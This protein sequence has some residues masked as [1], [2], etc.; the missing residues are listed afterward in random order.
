MNRFDNDRLNSAR[1]QALIPIFIEELKADHQCFQLNYKLKNFEI[2]FQL[3]H[4][5]EGS[6]LNFGIYDLAD[7]LMLIRSALRDQNTEQAEVEVNVL[8]FLIL[9]LQQEAE[10]LKS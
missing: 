9:E 1:L 5:I 3:I 10:T 7:Q 2:C 6:S 8:N 4:K